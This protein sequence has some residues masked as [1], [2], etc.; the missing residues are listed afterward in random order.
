MDYFFD[1]ESRMKDLSREI[2]GRQ[3]MQNSIS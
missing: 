2:V 1:D 3:K